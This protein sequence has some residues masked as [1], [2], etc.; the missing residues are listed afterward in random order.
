MAHGDIRRLYGLRADWMLAQIAV[1]ADRLLAVNPTSRAHGISLQ[2]SRRHLF[3]T[4]A[5]LEPFPRFF[6]EFARRE[7]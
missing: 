2:Q 3:R 5:P 6:V 7:R 1:F 4:S